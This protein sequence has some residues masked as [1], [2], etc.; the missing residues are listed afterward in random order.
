MI[1]EIKDFRVEL[2][3][4]LTSVQYLKPSREV[5]LCYTYLQRSFAW[6]GET[7][8]ELGSANPYPNSMDPETDIIDPV[9]IETNRSPD[10][11]VHTLEYLTELTSQTKKV[12]FFRACIDHVIKDIRGFRKLVGTAEYDKCLEQ[13]YI[14]LTDAKIAL[15]WE[16]A[17]IYNEENK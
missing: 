16:L 7:L 2:D 1:Q 13:S 3:R 12:K 15:G 6:L 4:F 9:Q 10:P 14:S 17:R 8:K 5:S 11:E